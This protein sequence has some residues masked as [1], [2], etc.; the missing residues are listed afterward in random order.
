M[1]K[2]E[3]DTNTSKI[4]YEEFEQEVWTKVFTVYEITVKT[5]DKILDIEMNLKSQKTDTS[6]IRYQILVDGR[7][8]TG[9]YI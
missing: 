8:S 5:L 7:L 6:M 1:S 4:D 2:I 9:S 3:T